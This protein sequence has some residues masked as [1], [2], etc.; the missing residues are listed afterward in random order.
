MSSFPIPPKLRPLVAYLDTL[1]ARASIERLQELLATSNATAEDVRDFIR[2]E[3]GHYQRNLVALGPW[4]EVLVICWH[5]GQRSPIHN[6]AQSTC[7]LKVLQGTCTETYFAHSPCGQVVALSSQAA[8]PI[9]Y[10][11]DGSEPDAASPLYREPLRLPLPSVLHAATVFDGRRVGAA[12]EHD[13]TRA[14][15]LARTGGALK[16]CSGALV[17]RLEDDAPVDGA[18]AFFDV[19]LFD[20]CWIW[21]RAPLDGVRAIAVTVGQVPN[22][23]QL[24]NDAAKIVPR[25]RPQTPGGELRVT[26]D[27]CSGAT[28]A[29][30]PL[31]RALS[32]PGLT[33]LEARIAPPSGAHDLCFVFS[34]RGS[35]PLWAIDSVRL[36]APAH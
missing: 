30:L 20:P 1:T 27:S 12:R 14:A 8:L 7:G 4:Y 16:Q 5:S 24:A 35:D 31:A 32:N 18:R 22:N 33:T 17:L 34:G 19:D 25:P 3:P 11:L 28:L 21:P 10:T 29:T 13:V 15:R 2:F 36:A 9:R 26:L 6:H 23:F